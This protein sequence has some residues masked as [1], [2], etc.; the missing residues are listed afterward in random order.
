MREL[1]NVIQFAL[2]S[3]EETRIR[4]GDLPP[5][6]RGELAQPERRPTPLAMPAF[7]LARSNDDFGADDILSMDEIEKVAIEQALKATAGN[8]SLAARQLGLG[9]TTLYRKMMAYGMHVSE[10]DKQMLKPS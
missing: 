9:R 6:Y 10:K 2:V 4:L 3:C 1:E 5:L 7:P 8:V